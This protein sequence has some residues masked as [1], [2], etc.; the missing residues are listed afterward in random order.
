[1]EENSQV[2]DTSYQVNPISPRTATKIQDGERQW[3]EGEQAGSPTTATTLTPADADQLLIQ[4]RETSLLSRLSQ[5]CIHSQ[6]QSEPTPFAHRNSTD[7]HL[8]P[9]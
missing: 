7:A 3:G 8:T 4:G 5:F 6:S 2:L 9:F 1:M